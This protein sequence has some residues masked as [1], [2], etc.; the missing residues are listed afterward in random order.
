MEPEQD[1]SLANP[2]VSNKYQGASNVLNAALRA[3][4]EA[5]RPGQL[6][7][8]LCE[9]GD[10]AIEE[11][12]AGVFNKKQ[13]E[14]G[15]AFPTC[16]SVNHICAYYSPIP[17]E[18]VALVEGDVVKINMGAHVDGFIADAATTFV[19][20]ATPEAPA[21]G[22]KADVILAARQAIE[23]VIRKIRVGGTNLE[24]TE[25]IAKFAEA[26]GVTAVEGVLSHQLKQHVMDGNRTIINKEHAEQHVDEITFEANE[27]YDIDV[28][29]TTGEG[30]PR[31]GEFRTTVFK[32]ALDTTYSLKLKTSRAFFS[33]VSRR[34]P[35]LMFSLRGFSDQKVKTT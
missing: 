25:T 16:V 12:L 10:N 23:G 7:S 4:V 31:E 18:T 30:K 29:M 8:E 28:F 5:A 6:I 2:L 33:E 24:L 21:T 13:I 1:Q 3:V 14:K 22:R 20:G 34:Y 32:R 26:Y 15:V 17:E 19:L 35:T 27:V 11:G 9:F